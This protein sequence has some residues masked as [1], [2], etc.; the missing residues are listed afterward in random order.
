MKKAPL[1]F[2]TGLLMS[3]GSALAEPHPDLVA[4][5][6][7]VF[8]MAGCENCHTDRKN[9]GQPMAGGV[10][11]KTPL[12]TFYTPNISPDR[13]TGIGSW[14]EDDFRRALREGRRPDGANYY[15][16]FPYTSYTNL[17][18]QDIQALWA[19][20][21][22]AAPV[23]QV[24]TPHQLPWYVRFRPLLTVWK[25]LFFKRGPYQPDP[26]KSAEWN[27]GAYLVRGPGH[28]NECHTE[29]NALGGIDLNKALAGTNHGPE[30]AR[31][32]NITPEPNTGIGK[33]NAADLL[34]YLKTG[35]RP[36][37]DYVG[38]LMAEMIDNGLKYQSG[39]DLKAIATY[40]SG[41]P[42]VR[43]LVIGHKRS[44]HKSMVEDY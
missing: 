3:A 8:R 4:H 41:V 27:R 36:D 30:G 35:L 2:L 33:W 23:R 7:E 34:E 42:A 21:R 26:A 14:R 43:N 24:N 11:L 25:W 16:S 31:I 28:C 37:G 10:E 22:T 6:Q 32:P 40:L 44:S 20:M 1:L 5:G 13:E 39:V 29:R 9:G 15:P 18:D 19:Y 38:G 17:S 12:G